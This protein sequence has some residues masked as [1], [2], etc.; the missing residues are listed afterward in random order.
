MVPP[1]GVEVAS[2]ADS[3]VLT[4][5]ALAFVALL[6]RE[7]GPRRSELLALRHERRGAAPRFLPETMLDQ[8]GRLAGR[9][10]ARRPAST[11]A[12][13]SPGPVDRKMMINA[14]NSGA[15]VFMADFEDSCSPTWDERRQRPAQPLRRRARGRS[16]SIPRRRAIGSQTRRRRSSCAL[17]AGTCTSGTFSVDGEPVSASLF[18]FGLA[19]FHNAQRAARAWQRPVLLPAQAREPPRGASLERRVRARGGR[20]RVTARRNSLRRC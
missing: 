20:A 6:Q 14:L 8:G 2:P 15:R 13:R 11:A 18:D 12:S 4:T 16:P 17:A 5:E 19:C 3:D 10:A 7:L 9:A 1:A